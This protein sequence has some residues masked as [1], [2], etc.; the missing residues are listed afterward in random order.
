MLLYGKGNK[1]GWREGT[2]RKAGMYMQV[3][4]HGEHSSAP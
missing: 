4:I 2:V 3:N 1:L